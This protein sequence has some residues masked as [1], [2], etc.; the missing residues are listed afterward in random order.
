MGDYVGCM[1]YLSDVST[2]ENRTGRLAVADWASCIALSL[3]LFVSG[4]YLDAT[5]YQ[6]VM[7]TTLVLYFVTVI[8]ILVWIKE[9]EHRVRQESTRM[10]ICSKVF[11]PQAILGTFKTVFRKRENNKRMQI[12]V[13]FLSL[14]LGTISLQ[15]KLDLIMG[16]K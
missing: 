13:L 1:S 2:V 8:Y 14:S 6:T 5:D 7:S 16:Y 9:P 15:R 4:I 12:C 10:D 3:G 11:G